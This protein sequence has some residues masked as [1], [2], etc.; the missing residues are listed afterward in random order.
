MGRYYLLRN[1]SR[2]ERRGGWI[3]SL[4][5][6]TLSAQ[7]TNTVQIQIQFKIKTQSKNTTWAESKYNMAEVFVFVTGSKYRMYKSFELCNAEGSEV[8]TLFVFL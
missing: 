2:L 5:S 4:Q 8:Y 3:D 1:Y 6:T 7:N